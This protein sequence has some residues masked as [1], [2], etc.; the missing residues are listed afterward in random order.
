[1]AEWSGQQTIESQK[2]IN[3]PAETVF[4][5]LE[6]LENLPT[7][8][9][10]SNGKSAGDAYEATYTAQPAGLAHIPFDVK[11]SKSGVQSSTALTYD[12]EGPMLSGTIRWSLQPQGNSTLVSADVSYK[13]TGGSGILGDS[14][15]GAASL[16][17]LVAAN[18]TVFEQGMEKLRALCENQP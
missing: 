12:V 11:F 9:P 13:L 8:F 17:P 7:L 5:I 2:L 4:A 10:L 14:T 15:G 3:A 18:K 6:N 16:G 1:M